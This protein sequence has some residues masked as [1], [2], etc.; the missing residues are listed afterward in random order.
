M[1]SYN[2]CCNCGKIIN[3]GKYCSTCGMEVRLIEKRQTNWKSEY[4]KQFDDALWE[5]ICDPDEYGFNVGAKI[6][7]T[8]IKAM[9]KLKVLT[10]GTELKYVPTGAIYH[11]NYEA[12]NANKR[13]SERQYKDAESS[14]IG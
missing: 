12:A 8:E 7:H 4:R 6:N 9:L 14:V 1:R 2:K 3:N 5:V 10:Q 13:I 11:V